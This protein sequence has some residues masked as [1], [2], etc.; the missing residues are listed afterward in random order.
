VNNKMMAELVGGPHDGA[1]LPIPQL[2]EHLDNP[3]VPG[4]RRPDHDQLAARYR[5]DPGC[6]DTGGNLV[7]KVARALFPP[8]AGAG[9]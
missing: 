4:Q 2:H 7:T 8:P 6:V 3:L 5:L 1:T 9:A